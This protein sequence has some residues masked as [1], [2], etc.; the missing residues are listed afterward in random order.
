MMQTAR[1]TRG[2]L[3]SNSLSAL[4]ALSFDILENVGLMYSWNH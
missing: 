4:Q 3:N 1:L 2:I